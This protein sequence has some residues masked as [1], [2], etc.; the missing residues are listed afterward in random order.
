CIKMAIVHDLAESF[1]GDIT[2]HD[3]QDNLQLDQFFAGTQ[4]KF[5]TPLVQSWVAEL[6]AQRHR[7]RTASTPEVST[8]TTTPTTS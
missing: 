3:A 4:G 6:D 1:V 7:R 2:P 5:K 8:T